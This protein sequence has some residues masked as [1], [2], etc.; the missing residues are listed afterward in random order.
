MKRSVLIIDNSPSTREHTSSILQLGG[1]EVYEAQ[2]GKSGV[3]IAL[4]EIPDLIICDVIMPGLDGSGV[5]HV[6]G[7]NPTTASIPFIFQGPKAS[8][9]E[10]RMGMNLGADDYL[11]KPFE[12]A[13]LL[14]VLEVRLNRRALLRGLLEP[15][16]EQVAM[17]FRQEPSLPE[18]EQ[19]T[20][21]RIRRLMRRKEVIYMEGQNPTDIYYI[22]RGLIKTYRTNRDGK[23]L[24]TRFHRAGDFIGHLS[25]L[26][27]TVYEENAEVVAEAEVGFISRNEFL[28]MV[29]SNHDVSSKLIH[30]LANQLGDSETRLLGI[31]YDSVRQKVAQALLQM[32]RHQTEDGKP[33]RMA[34]R[35][36]SGLIGTATESLNRTLADFKDEGLIN[37]QQDG[38]QILNSNKLER[39]R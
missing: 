25:V 4:R 13:E 24:I 10:I 37:I 21:N 28:M 35:D 36:I 17:I 9:T 14:Q 26:R 20:E 39:I 16:P 15:D 5:F 6:L 2:D 30:M 1:Y 7:K 29:H 3:E 27:N 19:L 18:V 22:S 11:I 31:A 12:G 33:I 23:E 34:R 32:A 8:V 38:I